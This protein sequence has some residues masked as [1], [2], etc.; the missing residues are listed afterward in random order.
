MFAK[1]VSPTVNLRPA[2]ELGAIQGDLAQ[3]QG[4]GF[5]PPVHGWVFGNVFNYAVHRISRTDL[6]DASV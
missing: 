6:C 2:T 5:R 3:L 4:E 1:Q